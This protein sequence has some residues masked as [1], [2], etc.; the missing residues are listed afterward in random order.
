MNARPPDVVGIVIDLAATL[1]VGCPAEE[2]VCLVQ[3]AKL[4]SFGDFAVPH[5]VLEHYLVE[6][7]ESPWDWPIRAE[8]LAA[9]GKEF[10]DGEWAVN[11]D[12]PP[13]H[14]TIPG[15][16]RIIVA[17]SQTGVRWEGEAEVDYRQARPGCTQPLI[18]VTEM[19]VAEVPFNE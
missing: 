11:F 14:G 19:S 4:G 5:Y 12:P 8:T 17:N 15:T 13:L 3:D 6:I 7:P 1:L 18:Q 9:S 16:Q 2:I 10:T